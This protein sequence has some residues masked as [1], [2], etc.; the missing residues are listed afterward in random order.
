MGAVLAIAASVTLS[1]SAQAAGT[2][3][4]NRNPDSVQCRTN[5]ATPGANTHQRNPV[6]KRGT[7]VQTPAKP[8]CSQIPVND[9]SWGICGREC[10]DTHTSGGGLSNITCQD[11][12][13]QRFCVK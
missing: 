8:L 7:V 10:R 9:D 4:C 12:C 13:M 1:T 3:I 6:A 5:P 11:D 2:R